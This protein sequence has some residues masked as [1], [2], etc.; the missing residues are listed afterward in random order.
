VVQYSD[1]AVTFGFLPILA[2]QMGVGDVARSLLISLNIGG[3]T[4]ATLLNTLLL[5]R[6]KHGWLLSAGAFLQFIGIILIAFSPVP[7]Y[8]YVGTVCMGFAFGLMYPILVGMSIHAV[9]RSQRSTAMGIHQSLY[10]IGMFTGPWVSG[11]IADYMGLR[12]VFFMTA[13]GFLVLGSLF[14]VLLLKTNRSTA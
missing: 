14:L 11:V 13:G 2:Q 12:P 9:D 6:A 4:V 7:A 8:L 10:A 5:K 1:W 3:I